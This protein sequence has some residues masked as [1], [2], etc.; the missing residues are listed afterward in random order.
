MSDR[1]VIGDH[2]VIP[3]ADDAKKVAAII[4]D[5]D[6]ALMM[7]QAKKDYI[8]ETKKALKDDYG[9]TP[10]S[11]QTMIQLYHKQSAD[12]YFKEQEELEDLYDKLFPDTRGGE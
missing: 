11:I 2:V 5:I 4:K 3:D 12:K 8:K 7:I 10:K 6:N 1:E 9:L